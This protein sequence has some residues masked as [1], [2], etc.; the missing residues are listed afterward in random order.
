MERPCQELGQRAQRGKAAVMRGPVV[1]A[2]AAGQPQEEVAAADTPVLRPLNMDNL[3][4][5]DRTIAVIDTDVPLQLEGQETIVATAFVRFGR[6]Q[7]FRLRFTPFASEKRLQ[8]YFQV[9]DTAVLQPD[10]L[11]A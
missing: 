7:R 1:Y 8:T 10:E 2:Y 3:K 5:V 11:F 4:R 6:S 9:S